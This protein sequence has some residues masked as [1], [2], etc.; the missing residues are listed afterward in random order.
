MVIEGKAIAEIDGV[1]LT[2]RCAFSGLTP[3]SMRISLN[4]D[5]H[6]SKSRTAG[7]IKFRLPSF[8]YRVI[9]FVYFG[10]GQGRWCVPLPHAVAF[11]GYAV[12]V[13]SNMVQDRMS[14]ADQGLGHT[15]GIL[16]R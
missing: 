4:R 16:L 6:F 9:D 1:R 13:V 15:Y 3:R 7:S 5:S 14:W 2:S 10:A 8:C 12:S 11:E